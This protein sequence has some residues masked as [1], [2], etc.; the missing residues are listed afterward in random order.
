MLRDFVAVV[1]VFFG[2][3]IPAVNAN[4]LDRCAKLFLADKR[5]AAVQECLPLAQTGDKEAAF[6]LARI[7]AKGIED[8]PD[9]VAVVEWLKI[10]AANGHGEAA[11]NLAIAFERGKGTPKDMAE[12][13]KYYN[14]SVEAGNP[15]AMRNL[16]VIYERGEFA[17]QNNEQAFQLFRRSAEAGLTDSQLKT[18]VMLLNGIGTEKNPIAAR[19]WFDSAAQAGNQQAQLALGVLLIDTHPEKAVYWYEQAVGQGNPYAAHNLALYYAD[20]GNTEHDLLQALAYADASLS[21]GNSESRPLYNRILKQVQNQTALVGNQ[22]GSQ[23]I[24]KDLS[25]L[26]QQPEERYVIQ[27]ARLNSAAGGDQFLKQH[28]L[29]GMA[30]LVKLKSDNDY[31]VLYNQDFAD[32]A[33]AQQSIAEDLPA[34]LNAEAW[35]R[36]YRS[37]Y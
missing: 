17:P 15:K 8:K 32:E 34:S 14:L 29:E 12:A 28:Q 5:L 1:L 6:V 10:S 13:V 2:L 37:L 25:W 9:W 3:N 36:S 21:L 23:V 19:Y 33:A 27:L 31:V 35:V 7:Y 22:A 16:A 26:K 11:Y 18:G 4:S 20:T 30:E 24:N